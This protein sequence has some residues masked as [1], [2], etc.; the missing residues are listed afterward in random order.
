VNISLQTDRQTDTG[1]RTRWRMPW[2]CARTASYAGLTNVDRVSCVQNAHM[3]WRRPVT[4]ENMAGHFHRREMFAVT[5]RIGRVLLNA[6]CCFGLFLWRRFCD[7]F[8]AKFVRGL[9]LS[10]QLHRPTHEQNACAAQGHVF[11]SG[12]GE[13]LCLLY[14]WTCIRFWH[15]VFSAENL[16]LSHVVKPACVAPRSSCCLLSG[17]V[18]IGNRV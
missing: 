13:S 1:F 5:Y 18:T 10:A 17:V 15:M 11:Y 6:S 4:I 7:V 3:L 14:Y 2:L 16:F 9:E 12:C 8:E